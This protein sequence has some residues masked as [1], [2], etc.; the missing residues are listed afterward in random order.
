MPAL[1]YEQHDGSYSNFPDTQSLVSSHVNSL[2][3]PSEETDVEDDDDDEKSDIGSGYG[4][5][6]TDIDE[7]LHDGNAFISKSP[8]GESGLDTGPSVLGTRRK[9]ALSPLVVNS[10]RTRDQKNTS[11]SQSRTGSASANVDL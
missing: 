4:G 6:D 7:S 8:A 1:R 2:E 10:T 3:D 5:D 9:I 11:T